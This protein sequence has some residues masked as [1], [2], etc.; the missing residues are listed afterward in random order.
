[1]PR[2]SNRRPIPSTSLIFLGVLAIPAA[3]RP[4]STPANDDCVSAD[5]IL[6]TGPY[7]GTN[8]GASTDGPA[9]C[10]SIGADVWY[11]WISPIT[12]HTVV[13]LCNSVTDF[14]TVL[15]VY[16]GGCGGA[17]LACNDDA[18]SCLFGSTLSS[19]G[20][21]AIEGTSYRIR[22]GGHSGATGSFRMTFSSGVQTGSDA[23]ATPVTV[24]G[25]GPH[26]FDLSVATTGVEGQLNIACLLGGTAG[27]ESDVWFTW[28]APATGATTIETCGQTAMNTKIAVYEGAGCPVAPPL[29][30]ADDTCAVQ[31][32]VTFPA[33]AGTAY[34]FQIGVFPG[35]PAFAGGTFTVSGPQP[36]NGCVPD[37]GESTDSAGLG[38][39]GGGEQVFLQRFGAPGDLTLVHSISAAYGTPSSP[40]SASPVGTL[41]VLTVF[42]DPD[43]DGIPD[44]LVLAARVSTVVHSVDTDTFGAAAFPTPPLIDGIYFAGVSIT[45]L[46]GHSPMAFDE[47]TPSDGRSWIAAEPG[48]GINYSDLASSTYYGDIA[49]L[50]VSGTWLVRV[51]CEPLMLPFCFPG[52]GG[53]VACPCD[54]PPSGSGRGCDNF[55]AATGGASLAG[56]GLPSLAAD[57]LLLSAAGENATSLTVFWTGTGTNAPPGVLLGAG[58]RCVTGFK[59]IYKGS[60]SGGA[61]TRPGLADPSVSARSAAVGAPIE[62]GDVRYYFAVYRDPGAATACGNPLTTFNATSAL[63]VH[64][65]P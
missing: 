14:D 23:C 39:A 48:L 28:T 19:V 55:G 17:L 62:P 25:S 54:N 59:R 33:V 49:V 22:I 16:S 7:L 53:V 42:D 21:A 1:M 36:G 46:P 56:S 45:S 15:A 6:G 2:S 63:R 31:A 64:W 11:E 38:A 12:A 30:C 27:L 9:A 18:A 13:S 10:G 35:A 4:S 51:Q 29:G 20:F 58:V 43:D 61:I 40:G 44:D 41:V 37:S 50:V 34:T 26:A 65:L 32:A 52:E 5:L 24:A 3:A 60:A 57:S 47:S 8:A